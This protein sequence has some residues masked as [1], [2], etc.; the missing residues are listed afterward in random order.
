VD[1]DY[2]L[3]EKV[4]CLR[5]YA[6]LKRVWEVHARGGRIDRIED[7]PG[8]NSAID[9]MLERRVLAGQVLT[10]GFLSEARRRDHPTV[11]YYSQHLLILV[12]DR[13]L[14]DGLAT[15]NVAFHTGAF[16]RELAVTANDGWS[17]R[18]RYAAPWF[19]E[20]L[21]KL[22]MGGTLEYDPVDFTERFVQ[23]IAFNRPSWLVDAPKLP[24]ESGD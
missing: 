1:P 2:S 3:G 20:S 21:R 16:E 12:N 6:T 13:L 15:P 10:M 11:P 17:F 9:G 24:R 5:D 7:G 18:I 4:Y 14:G 8:P 19:R 23:A 22:D